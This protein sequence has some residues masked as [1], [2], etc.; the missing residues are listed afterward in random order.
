VDGVAIRVLRADDEARLERLF[1]RLSPESV[2]RRFF[3]LYSS[4]PPGALR[5]LSDL[6]HDTKDAAVAAVGDEVVG[7]GRYAAVPGRRGVA[8]VAVVVDD[9]WQGRGLG[10][11]LLACA[12]SLARLHGYST[13]TASVLADNAPA[14]RM[15]R[16]AF[17]GAVWTASGAEY[18]LRVP[19]TVE[20]IPA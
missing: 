9:A 20:R 5:E 18:E 8:E 15:L 2:Y 14:I 10:A 1:Y 13:L 17:P 11:R 3:T 12:A 7:V 4:P 6:D 19:L 16:R